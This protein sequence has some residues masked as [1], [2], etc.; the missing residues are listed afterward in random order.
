M[1][2]Q[3][4]A[5]KPY[6]FGG[7]ILEYVATEADESKNTFIELEGDTAENKW[8]ISVDPSDN[9]LKLSFS[10]DGGQTYVSKFSF[11]PI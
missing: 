5:F 1:P 8:K 2:N 7:S 10:S 3:N 9:T 6:S 11:S 4:I